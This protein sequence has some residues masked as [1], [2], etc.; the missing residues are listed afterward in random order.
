MRK[1]GWNEYPVEQL[2][3]QFPSIKDHRSPFEIYQG[4]SSRVRKRRVNRIF[5]PGLATIS[6]L[7]ILAILGYPIMREVPGESRGQFAGRDGA[8]VLERDEGQ[9]KNVPPKEEPG[10]VELPQIIE[11]GEDAEL[12]IA[13]SPQNTSGEN[14][15]IQDSQAS[16]QSERLVVE[17]EEHSFTMGMPDKMGTLTIP[18]SFVYKE[19][20]SS[21]L[22]K[23][24]QSVGTLAEK[25]GEF[26]KFPLQGAQFAEI[27]EKGRKWLEIDFPADSNA[28][29]SAYGGSI[30]KSIEEILAW[31]G[32]EKAVVSTDGQP[33]LYAGNNEHFE[34]RV[35]P[36]H[37]QTSWYLL[38][39]GEVPAFAVPAGET[40][41]RVEE[42]IEAMKSEPANEPQLRSAIPSGVEIAS[43]DSSR[44]NLVITFAAESQAAIT[45]DS[46]N[47]ISSMYDCILLTAKGFGYKTVTFTGIKASTI[48]GIPLNVPVPVPKAPNPVKTPK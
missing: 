16:R 15:Q 39:K 35:N 19:G 40:F 14:G 21:L 17:T 41:Q 32:Y 26:T 44:D 33:G 37:R 24:L 36:E 5:I 42:A 4:I 20:D 10:E 12:H 1:S 27:Q 13:K 43:I 31:N 6:A 11:P 34:I 8:A 22:N 47:L 46:P 3:Q 29:S 18:V 7:F 28:S 30:L 25:N 23:A 9:V 2:L 38:F 45:E 48:E